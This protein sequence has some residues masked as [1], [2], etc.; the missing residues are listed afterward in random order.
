MVRPRAGEQV[1][2]APRPQRQRLLPRNTFQV[3][4]PD[5]AVATVTINRSRPLHQQLVDLYRERH[6]KLRQ[7]ARQQDQDA[8][9]ELAAWG[10]LAAVRSPNYR[11]YYWAAIKNYADCM[12]R[13]PSTISLD[14]VVSLTLP[15]SKWAT[16]K[17]YHLLPTAIRF[18]YCSRGR[19][20]TIDEEQ[21][22]DTLA[23]D[24]YDSNSLEMVYVH[25]STQLDRLSAIDR[26][27]IAD[28]CYDAPH[29]L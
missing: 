24:Y 26:D 27:R 2:G 28:L 5:G 10:Q 1:A 17:P 7:Q 23:N 19:K 21:T 15:P 11:T 14:G 25:S 22:A 29:V 13:D 8:A 16:M 20:H 4:D 9:R 18:V 3:K 6:E 12:L